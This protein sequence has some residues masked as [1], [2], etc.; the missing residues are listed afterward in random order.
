MGIMSAIAAFSSTT[1]A[2]LVADRWGRRKIFVTGAIWQAGVLFIMAGSGMAQPVTFSLKALISSMVPLYQL[3][4][5][6]GSSSVQHVIVAEVPHQTLR[7]K[8]QQVAGVVNS[9]MAYVRSLS[10]ILTL[11]RAV[12]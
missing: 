2:L 4:F 6:F 7:D 11:G 9:I 12:Y 3:G 10:C 1:L 8:S 5:G